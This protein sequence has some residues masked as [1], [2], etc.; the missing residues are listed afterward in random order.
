MPCSLATHG[1]VSGAPQPW[2]KLPSASNSMTDGAGAQHLL[3]GG[4]SVAPFSSSVSERGR[5]STQT[6]SLASTATLAIWPNSQLLGSGLGQNGS[7]WNFGGSA[8]EEDD[9]NATTPQRAAIAAHARRLIASSVPCPLRHRLCRLALVD[10]PLVQ[11]VPGLVLGRIHRAVLARN[12]GRQFDDIAVGVAEVDRADELVVGD[13]AHLAALR[14]AFGEHLVQRVRL[15]L[16]RDMQVEIVLVLELERHV[17]RLEE[18]EAGTVVE[19]E[20][21]M[22][23]AGTGLAAGH[24]GIDLEG[25]DQRQSEEFLVEFPRLLRVAA[26]IGVVMQT[27]DHQALMFRSPARAVTW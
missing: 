10:L 8:A 24:G 18:G 19:L 3:R 2:M 23:H 25:V 5:C 26:A 12:L 9:E 17:G 27:L 7:T 14:L 6:W 21:G 22:Q 15:D 11:D 20:E 13:T 4:L 16:E 1:L